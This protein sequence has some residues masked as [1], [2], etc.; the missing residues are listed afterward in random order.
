V[1]TARELLEQADALMRRNRERAIHAERA[2]AAAELLE[3]APEDSERPVGIAE[4]A[5]EIPELTDVVTLGVPPAQPTT[6]GDIPELVDAVEEIE[7]ELA[8]MADLPGERTGPAVEEIEIE[9]ASIADLPGERTG[10]SALSHPDRGGH[11]GDVP[12][13]ASV[14][15]APTAAPARERE[16]GRLWSVFSFARKPVERVAIPAVEAAPPV[17]VPA[18]EAAP[19]ADADRTAV[20]RTDATITA[21]PAVESPGRDTPV[22]GSAAPTSP[23]IDRSAPTPALP[24]AGPLSTLTID[25]G[26]SAPTASID[27]AVSAPT[28]PI[29]STV[30]A[31]S[32]FSIDGT[33]PA[34]AS[35]P[36]DAAV[37]RSP[38]LPALADD[39]ARWEALA[40][41]IRMQVLQR[42]DI[43]TDTRLREQL[44][45]LLQPIVDRASAELVTTINEEVGKLIRAYIAEAIE[46]EIETWRKGNS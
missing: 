27:N 37:P 42:I 16:P 40:E 28:L 3:R 32:S 21:V 24:S 14:D 8:S 10:P 34:S 23:P 2:D 46:R 29:E 4:R 7:I 35:L 13:L 9:L 5:M 11:G 30:S 12:G 20:V 18:V 31:S 39:W 45:V 15:S 38:A 36:A 6:P 44:S 1:P 41:E 19:P 17:A 33:V 43:F 26:G 25:G 22:T